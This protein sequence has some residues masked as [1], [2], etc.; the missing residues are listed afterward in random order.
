MAS[1]VASGPGSSIEKLSAR[2]K[3][4]SGTQR[5]SSMSSRC[6]I[7]IWPAGP[8]KLMKPSLT[9]KRNASPN[10]TGTTTDG[11]TVAAG[12]EGGASSGTA[13]LASQPLGT[14]ADL[15]TQVLVELFGGEVPH[16][17]TREVELDARIAQRDDALGTGDGGHGAGRA[18]IE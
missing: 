2:R 1:S 8:P 12:A 14:A 18:A 16:L 3:S 15:V 5:L 10:E 6:M 9:Q 17:G 4:G 13:D 7:A 11:T